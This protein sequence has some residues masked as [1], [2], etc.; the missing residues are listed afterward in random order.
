MA[1]DVEEERQL[2]SDLLYSVCEG[3]QL[4]LVTGAGCSV[5]LPTSIPLS[6]AIAKRAHDR[7]VDDGVLKRGQC[8]NPEDLSELADTVFNA[9]LPAEELV[10]RMPRGD[11][12]GAPPNLGHLFAAALLIERAIA[13]VVTLNFDVAMTGALQQL[14]AKDKVSILRGP[15]DHNQLSDPSLIYLHGDAYAEAEDWILRT[16][17]LEEWSDD[18]WE[19]V[20]AS[21]VLSAPAVVFVGLGSPAA[22]LTKSV[23]RIR[24]VVPNGVKIYQVD[25]L[26]MNKS[27]FAATLGLSKTEYFEVGWSSFMERLSGRLADEHCAEIRDACRQMTEREGWDDEDVDDMYDSLRSYGLLELGKLRARWLLD[28]SPYLPRNDAQVDQ[29]A[30]LVLVLCL[31]VRHTKSAWLLQ[32]QALVE[33]RTGNVVRGVFA[34]ASGGQSRRWLSLEAEV[35]RQAQ[36]WKKFAPSVIVVSG[37]VGNES[38]NPTPPRLIIDQ[39]DPDSILSS[40]LP[41]LVSADSLRKNPTLLDELLN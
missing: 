20:I 41:V 36:Q 4:V 25:P 31:I 32:D 37:F 13:C 14:G 22:V 3:G 6:S 7:L 12:R 33:L 15:Q 8:S 19:T 2:L 24:E 26:P 10:R 17:H 16:V 1:P 11:M 23:Q 5:E 9:K 30:D 21:R 28:P 29:I 35:S 38:P 18:R 34:F 40:R 39:D 27:S